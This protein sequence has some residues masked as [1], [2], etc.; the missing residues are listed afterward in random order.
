MGGNPG[1][2]EMLPL[3]SVSAGFQLRCTWFSL[4]RSQKALGKDRHRNDG[5]EYFS[6]AY[7]NACVMFP[8]GNDC[9][10]QYCTG[11][12]AGFESEQS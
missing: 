11:K 9:L 4:G 3:V 5:S 2:L 10:Q 8:S 6:T 7:I 1:P 12:Y